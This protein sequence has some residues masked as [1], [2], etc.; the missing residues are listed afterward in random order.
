MGRVSV[1]VAGLA[2][3]AAFTLAGSAVLA[4]MTGSQSNDPTAVL[5][6]NL[7]RLLG[8][9]RAGLQRVGQRRIK[10]LAAPSK[11]R[12]AVRYDPK[13]LD[14]LPQ[15][16]GAAPWKCLTEALYFEARGET[17]KGQFAVAEVILNR[18]ASPLYPDNVCAV[19][20]QGTGQRNRCQF[21]YTCDGRAEHVSDQRLYARLGKVA[22]LMLDGSP[23]LLTGGATHYHNRSV[24]PNWAR[25]FA[26]TASIG[27]HVFYRQPGALAAN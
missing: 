1:R 5:G 7:A 19:V 23:R 13:W 6:D 9:E 24:D 22:R 15:A 4:E 18:V 10:R 8:A 20:N 25:R 17:V 2:A 11:A 12:E 27:Q 3:A 16:H 21:S 14:A 26:R